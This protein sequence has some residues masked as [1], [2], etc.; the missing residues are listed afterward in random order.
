MKPL[1]LVLFECLTNG[2]VQ[3]FA[4]KRL[5]QEFSDTKV[6]DALRG[7][8]CPETGHNDNA[9]VA[10]DS[11]MVE[12]DLGPENE[13][14]PWSRDNLRNIMKL[15][16]DI[17]KVE[18]PRTPIEQ[19]MVR[20]VVTVQAKTAVSKVARMLHRGR[21]NQLPVVDM[22]DH[23]RGMVFDIDLLSVLI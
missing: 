20:Q 15:Y 7:K 18:I 21:F 12:T 13:G 2:L 16:F 9:Q 19:F 17:G 4:C 6:T 10:V 1:S 14:V 3:C 11:K 5:A 22:A 8:R 23:L